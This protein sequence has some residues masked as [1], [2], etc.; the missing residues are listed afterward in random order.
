MINADFDNDNEQTK[1][2]RSEALPI[3]KYSF[4]PRKV[5]P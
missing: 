4:A 3:P 5:N 2:F 1:D